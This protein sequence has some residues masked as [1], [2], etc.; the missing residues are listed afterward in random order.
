[1]QTFKAGVQRN[2]VFPPLNMGLIEISRSLFKPYRNSML[3]T[4]FY[5]LGCFVVFSDFSYNWE[6]ILF[7]KG[8]VKIGEIRIL[9]IV[10]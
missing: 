1:M 5:V 10:K 3:I 2:V 9:K 4:Q 7:R 8:L 6:E